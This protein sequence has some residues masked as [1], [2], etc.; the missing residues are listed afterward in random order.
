MDQVP[1]DF[2]LGES[3]EPGASEEETERAQGSQDTEPR[4]YVVSDLN[5]YVRNLLEG[6]FPDIWVRGEISNF[7]AHSSGHFYFSLKDNR[8]QIN[9]V[10]FKGFNSKL[11]FRPETGMEVLTRGKITV[12]EPR[13]NYQLFCQT[14]EP[15]GAGALQQGFEQLKEK[16][17]SEGLFSKEH[18]KALPTLPNHVVLIT[19]PTGAAVRDMVNVLGR[20][21][22]GLKITVIPVVVQGDGAAASIV[23][24]IRKANLIKDADVTIVGRGGGSMEDLWSFNDEGVARA[25]FN[26]H[27]PVVSA[28][29]HEVDFTIA[30]FVADVR[31]STPSVAAELVVKSVGEFNEELVHLKTR[32]YRSWQQVVV[33][34]RERVQR[35]RQLLVDP[36]RRLEDLNLRCDELVARLEP[37]MKRSIK[38]RQTRVNHLG[39]LMDS[40]SPL[41]IL[42]RG[43]AVVRREEIIHR[44]TDLK[45]GDEVQIQLGEGGFH[46]QV[47]QID[48]GGP[49]GF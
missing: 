44:Y 34:G 19:S 7:K 1:L 49:Y 27:I 15:V 21:F 43:Y 5:H 29:G 18:K 32:L 14:M 46:A 39:S 4:V 33:R 9:A 12:Y 13:G 40:L 36:Q 47:V 22:K 45:R 42:K 25:I 2:N 11:R 38:D 3:K 10:M 26:S 16:L 31:A 20:R 28:V 23:E 30:D 37:S 24:G 35:L 6:E 8:S 41:R 17:K 48:K